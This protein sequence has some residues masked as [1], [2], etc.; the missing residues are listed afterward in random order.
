M[1]HGPIFEL[2]YTAHRRQLTALIAMDETRLWLERGELVHAQGVP[3]RSFRSGGSVPLDQLLRRVEQ[4]G[5]DLDFARASAISDIG[6]HCARHAH[7]SGVME[8]GH[9]VRDSPWRV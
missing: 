1:S 2:L 7:R 8:L 5:A 4:R 3:W 6:L 9:S